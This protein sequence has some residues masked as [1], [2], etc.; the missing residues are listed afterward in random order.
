MSEGL[1]PGYRYSTPPDHPATHHP[2]YTSPCP[3]GVLPVLSAVSGQR[4][5][6]VGLISVEQLSLSAGIS[7]IRGITEVYNLV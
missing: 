6:V 3:S 4:E 5:E 7:D 2:G 1:G